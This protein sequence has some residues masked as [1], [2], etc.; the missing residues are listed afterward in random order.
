VRLKF[1]SALITGATGFVGS[2]LVRRLAESGVEVIALVRKGAELANLGGI[3]RIRIVEVASFDLA[4]LER[5]L[6]GAT[7]EVVFNLASYGVREKDRDP[8]LMLEGNVHLVWR[9]LR[10]TAAWPLKWFVQTGSC[11]EYGQPSGRIL[12]GED[13]PLRPTSLYGAAKAAATLYGNALA[14]QLGIPFI[15]LRLFGVF[16]T[17]ERAERLV[18]YLITQMKNDR[19]ADLTPGEQLRDLVYVDDAVDALVA[20]AGSSDLKSGSVYNVCSSRPVRVRE[21]AETVADAMQK[22]RALLRFGARPYRAD[23]PMW[24]VGDNRRFTA[25]THWQPRTTLLEGVQRMLC[26][27][28]QVH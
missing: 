22:P 28:V 21:I 17:G 20:A 5:A 16:G 18:P 9:F 3:S 6:Q 15:V 12:L 24:L 27:E 26:N 19:P 1:E 25:T 13:Q 14:H 11:S 4:E 23:E 7:S 8:E 10:V 2:R